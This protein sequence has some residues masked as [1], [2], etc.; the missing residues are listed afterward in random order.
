MRVAKLKKKNVIEFLREI[1]EFGEVYGPVKKVDSYI[2]AK[3]EPERFS[4]DALRTIIS[5]KKFF[6]PPKEKMFSFKNG[7]WITDEDDLDKKRIIFGLHPCDIHGILILDR[8]FLE[9]Y[10]DP[11]YQRR[12]NNTAIIGLSCEPDDKCFCRSTHT[13]YV[14]EGFDLALSDIGDEY[15]VWIGSSLGDDLQKLAEG[16]IEEKVDEKDITKYIE[17][18]RKRD[19]LFKL[20]IDLTAMPDIFE[21]SYNE[22]IWEKLGKYCISC[23]QCSMVCPT[24]NCYDVEDNYRFGKDIERLRHWDSCNFREYSL[25]AGGHNFREARSE[26][27]KLWYTHKLAGFMS[28]FGKPAC[29]GCGRCIETCPV[30]I[31]VPNVV[32]ALKREKVEALWSKEG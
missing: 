8:L 22:E 6:T 26:R 4:F 16:L 24:C 20:D 23:G 17:W 2:F 5:P 13:D 9:Q 10:P 28:I 25:V 27:L 12:R 14:E 1:S 3:E 18:R 7:E 11:Y 19:K 31:N 15:L 32:K 30:G 29:V 21:I